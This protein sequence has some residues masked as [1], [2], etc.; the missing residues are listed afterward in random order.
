[1]KSLFLFFL[2]SLS[3]S[4]SAA[5]TEME[6]LFSTDGGKQWTRDF[7]VVTLGKPQF[8]LKITGK[9][10]EDPEKIVN[11]DIGCRIWNDAD[12]ASA[13]RGKADFAGK[14]VYIQFPNRI[15]NIQPTLREFIYEV[16]LG[17]RG[18]GVLGTGNGRDSKGKIIHAE[19][20][21][22]AARRPGEVY[23][24]AMVAYAVRE[25][26]SGKLKWNLTRTEFS[27]SIKE[28]AR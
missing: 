17:A 23:F 6:L 11:R 19:L 25:N 18:T 24:T 1:M 15:R 28:E 2:L 27:V 13:G 16:D 21:P 10:K 12:F 7:P 4:V 3:L 20:P 5:G 26:P 22:C 9:V 14:T 8:L